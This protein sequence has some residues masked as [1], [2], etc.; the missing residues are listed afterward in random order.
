MAY[1]SKGEDTT[2]SPT[3]TIRILIDTTTRLISKGM[4]I[5]EYQ[6]VAKIVGII[7]HQYSN[8]KRRNII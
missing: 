8:I 2:L 4:C 7:W 5:V 3:Y 1:K 6:G